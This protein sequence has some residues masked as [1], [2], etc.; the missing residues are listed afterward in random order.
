MIETLYK[1]WKFSNLIAKAESLHGQSKKERRRR[2]RRA[3]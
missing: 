3:Q 1:K 2:R